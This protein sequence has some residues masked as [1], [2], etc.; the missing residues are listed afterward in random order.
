M[1]LMLPVLFLGWIF[2]VL[3]QAGGSYVT[4]LYSRPLDHSNLSDLHVIGLLPMSGDT[5]PGGPSQL[6]LLEWGAENLGELENFLEGYSLVIHI[7]DT[8]VG[9]IRPRKQMFRF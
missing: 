4:T 6:P 5:W 3:V 8:K 7:M 9:L 2:P 1:R